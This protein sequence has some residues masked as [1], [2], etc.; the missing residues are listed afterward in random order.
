MKRREYTITINWEEKGTLQETSSDN[1]ARSALLNLGIDEAEQINVSYVAENGRIER[2]Y[3]E[4][5]LDSDKN[6]IFE[7]VW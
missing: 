4:C 3:W 6:F 1:A 5:F 2:N 7:M